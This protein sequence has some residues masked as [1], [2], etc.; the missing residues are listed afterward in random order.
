MRITTNRP[1]ARAA[2]VG[3]AAAALMLGLAS[4]ASAAT[5]VS[6]GHVDLVEIECDGGNLELGTHIDAASGPIHVEPGDLGDYTFAVG[7]AA[8]DPVSGE[9]VIPDD[10]SVEDVLPFLGFAYDE[11]G[12]CSDLN[13]PTLS[14]RLVGASGD[15]DVQVVEGTTVQ[16]DSTDL[17]GGSIALPQGTHQHKEWRFTDAGEYDL[18]FQVTG[19][20]LS[21]NQLTA[22]IE[23]G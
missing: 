14:V 10:E 7:T 11:E 4:G 22:H 12:E 2:G 5:V 8:L 20:S 1:A 23:V 6:S 15:G 9:Y 13:L 18:T 17:G 3:A 21:P 16:L 19:A